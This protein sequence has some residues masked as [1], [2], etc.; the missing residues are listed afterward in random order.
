MKNPLESISGTIISGIILT[1]VLVFF[2]KNFLL[3]GA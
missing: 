3:A 2:L 1:I